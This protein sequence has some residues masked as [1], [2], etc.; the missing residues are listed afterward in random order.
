M[1]GLDQRARNGVSKSLGI[2]GCAY[3]CSRCVLVASTVEAHH[4]TFFRPCIGGPGVQ[5]RRAAVVAGR[6][7]R[8]RVTGG[9]GLAA[10]RERR[11]VV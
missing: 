6:Q 1:H 9:V 2:G 3:T 4:R 10:Q 8:G 7:A 11:V 5:S